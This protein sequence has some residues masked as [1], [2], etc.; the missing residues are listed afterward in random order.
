VTFAEQAS[1]HDWLLMKPPMPHDVKK[2][3]D[4][5]DV[6][7]A[8]SNLLNP[9]RI[10]SAGTINVL[11]PSRLAKAWSRPLTAS[12]IAFCS[13]ATSRCPASTCKDSRVRRLTA[14]RDR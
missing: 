4:K 10:A 7:Q 11:F 14:D 1:H 6:S 8:G 9:F 3:P 12:Q 13:A 5:I 2:P